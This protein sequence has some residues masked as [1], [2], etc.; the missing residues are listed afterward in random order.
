MFFMPCLLCRGLT[1]TY[2]NY[3]RYRQLPYRLVRCLSC[4]L[5]QTEPR[6]TENFLY[7]WYQQ[8]D[9]LGEHEPYYRAVQDKNPWDTLE[10]MEIAR[11]FVLVKRTLE[12]GKKETR[13]L[14]V[15]SGHGL[16]LDLVKRAGWQGMGIELSTHATEISQK[17]F[18]IDVKNGTI[19]TVALPENSLDAVTLWDILEH[20]PDPILMMTKSFA[21]LKPGGYVFIDTPN[22]SS[23]LDWLVIQFACLGILGPALTFYGVHHLTLW[24]HATIRRLLT[25]I[26]FAS[27]KI[28]PATTLASRV[29]RGTKISDRFMRIGVGLIQ[30]IGRNLGRE[31]KMIIVAQKPL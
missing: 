7:D 23:F 20:V 26:G 3:G 14:E 18:D 8:Y 6:P 28:A 30:N 12:N 21:L 24:N 29:F 15:G 31:N 5:V 25:E 19:E 27:I 13:V 10:G 17:L 22:V 16:F 4:G 11:H 1:K 2:F 9:V